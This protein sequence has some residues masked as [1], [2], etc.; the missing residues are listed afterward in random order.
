MSFN[1]LQLEIVI[2]EA[3]AKRGGKCR[4]HFSGDVF[5]RDEKETNSS[6]TNL[7][8]ACAGPQGKLQD[9]VYNPPGMGSRRAPGKLYGAFSRR[10][11]CS[12]R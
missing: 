12:R 11:H 9:E 5:F 10:M 3:A 4:V 1:E 2:A 8:S 6:G 7:N